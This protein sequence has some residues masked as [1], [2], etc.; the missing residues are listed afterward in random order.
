MSWCSRSCSRCIRIYRLWLYGTLDVQYHWRLLR[1]GVDSNILADRTLAALC[2]IR[3]MDDTFLAR[4]DRL[5]W[6]FWHSAAA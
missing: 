4:H 3:H 2:G 1:I 5:L 6:P